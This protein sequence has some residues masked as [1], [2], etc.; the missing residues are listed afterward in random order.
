M[1]SPQRGLLS[2]SAVEAALR[3]LK[4]ALLTKEF[5][6][7]KIDVFI[8]VTMFWMAGTDSYR[9]SHNPLPSR[10]RRQK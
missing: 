7:G 4:L 6:E 2:R 5:L 8:S 9:Q 3:M 1:V 10:E